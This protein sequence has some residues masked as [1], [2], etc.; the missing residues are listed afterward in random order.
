M[1]GLIMFIIHIIGFILSFIICYKKGDFHYAAKYGDG[2]RTALPFDLLFDCFIWEF[3]LLFIII[4][5]IE[6]WFNGL[7]KQKDDKENES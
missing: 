7:F 6:E 3:Y 5:Y 2:I 1:I 4:S